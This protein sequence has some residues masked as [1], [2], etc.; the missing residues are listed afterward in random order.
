MN[1]LKELR[2]NKHL[3][4]MQLAERLD[5]DY[6]TLGHI[7]RGRRDFSVGSLKKACD[8]FGVSADYMLGKSPEEMLNGFVDSLRGDFLAET[9][10]RD[11]D[12]TQS[13]A[14]SVPE[15]VRTKIEILFLLQE[16]D[17]KASLDLI[18]ELAKLKQA[19]EDFSSSDEEG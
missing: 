3:T 2:L 12:V 10:H 8:F 1:R 11:G 15:P 14:A 9:A 18:F 16:I 4:L 5:V 13:L 17:K 6:S 7:E 19:Q